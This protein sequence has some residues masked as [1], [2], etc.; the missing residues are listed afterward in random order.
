MIGTG[1]TSLYCRTKNL[2]LYTRFAQ[3]SYGIRIWN[4]A[5]L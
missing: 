3:S 5:K 1:Q 2:L 4:I